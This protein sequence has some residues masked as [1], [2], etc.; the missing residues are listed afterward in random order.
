MLAPN[1]IPPAS[2]HP[3]PPLKREEKKGKKK[4][5]T[6]EDILICFLSFVIGNFKELCL[7]DFD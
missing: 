7:I 2:P 1:K 6:K 3:I 4:K 5:K